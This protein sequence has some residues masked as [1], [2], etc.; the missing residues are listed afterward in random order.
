M[1]HCPKCRFMFPKPKDKGKII[2]SEFVFDKKLMCYTVR[3]RRQ[4]LA[5]NTKWTTV[6]LNKKGGD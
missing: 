3:R 6:E 2:D 1:L 4:C 5:C